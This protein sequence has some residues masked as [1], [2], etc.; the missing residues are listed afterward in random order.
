MGCAGR[1]AAGGRAGPGSGSGQ[2]SV[3]RAPTA[4]RARTASRWGAARV[5]VPTG[6]SPHLPPTTH[7]SGWGAPAARGE[8][9][10]TPRFQTPAPQALHRSW[11][12]RDD[13]VASRRGADP[14]WGR[15]RAGVWGLG[16]GQTLPPRGPAGAGLEPGRGPGLREG[17]PS[18][19]DG[20]EVC[21]Q[22]R[23][24]RCLQGGQSLRRELSAQPCLGCRGTEV[25]VHVPK[26]AR[27][28][29]SR[30]LKATE[31]QAGRAVS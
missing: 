19:Q 7:C 17:R 14:S 8:R 10:P 28:R 25:S 23:V 2:V 1:L 16:S 24:G 9:P 3:G 30:R 15:A 12:L 20:L 29:A 5:S 4:A 18:V 22:G 11:W 27:G 21:G 26:D 31:G 13:P 6:R